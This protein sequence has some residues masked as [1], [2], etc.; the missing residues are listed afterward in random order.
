LRLLDEVTEGLQPSVVDAGSVDD[1]SA[2]RIDG[3]MRL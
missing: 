2:A 1:T 3:H